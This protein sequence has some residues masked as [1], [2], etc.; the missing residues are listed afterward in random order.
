MFTKKTPLLSPSPSL[1]QSTSSS[2]LITSLEKHVMSNMDTLVDHL[3]SLHQEGTVDKDALKSGVNQVS[4][5]AQAILIIRLLPTLLS[6]PPDNGKDKGDDVETED[7]FKKIHQASEILQV[8]SKDQMMQEIDLKA[9]Q[10]L[11]QIQNKEQQIRSQIDQ[12]QQAIAQL[13]RSQT[14]TRQRN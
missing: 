10:I 13:V 6:P 11:E 4:R 1:D 5:L 9:A 8:L 2:E 3:Q 14:Q 7:L 12:K